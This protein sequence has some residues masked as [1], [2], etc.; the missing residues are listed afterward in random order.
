MEKY[1]WVGNLGKIMFGRSGYPK[2]RTFF[3]WPKLGMSELKSKFSKIVVERCRGA[4]DI[5]QSAKGS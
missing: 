1:D 2:H 5:N 3:I 4:I